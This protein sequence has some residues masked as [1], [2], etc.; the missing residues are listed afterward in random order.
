VLGVAAY[1]GNLELVKYLHG[2]NKFNL[3]G[4]TS[5]IDGDSFPLYYAAKF[6]HFEVVKYLIE[7]G[8]R[9]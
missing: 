2:L 3:N 5:D 7:A 4:G 9:L 8:E 6:G 1:I